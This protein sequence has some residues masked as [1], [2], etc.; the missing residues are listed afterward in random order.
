MVEED[1]GDNNN[2][3][4]DDDDDDGIGGTTLKTSLQRSTLPCTRIRVNF[5]NWKEIYLV[6][7]N[8]NHESCY[9]QY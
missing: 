2:D 7:D 8:R 1:N 3:D 6:D 5:R 9:H 4:D